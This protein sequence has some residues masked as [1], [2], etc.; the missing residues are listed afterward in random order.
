VRAAGA[1][2]VSETPDPGA[3]IRWLREHLG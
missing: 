3:D 1:P 2:T